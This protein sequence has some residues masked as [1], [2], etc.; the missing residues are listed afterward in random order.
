MA[1][2]GRR[3]QRTKRGDFRLRLTRAERD[4]LRTL[5]GEL[6]PLLSSDDPSAVRLHPPGYSDDP[7]KDREYRELMREELD[8]ERRRH[9]EVMEQTIDSGRLDEE[10]LL[11]WLGA[12][13]D[14]RLVLGTKLDVTE[15]LDPSDVSRE[16]PRFAGL[17]V[18]AY[19]TWLEEQAVEALGSGLP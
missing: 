19:L 3:I 5:P 11:A 10:Q 1:A 14:L 17:A 13:N 8:A 6:R 15:D 4:L 12:M 18:Y 2:F 7:E 16:D 9:L